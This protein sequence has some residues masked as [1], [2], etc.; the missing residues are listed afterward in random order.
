MQ[1]NQRFC[2]DLA[3]SSSGPPSSKFQDCCWFI[4]I[5]I[6]T[7]VAPGIATATAPAVVYCY[8]CRFRHCWPVFSGTVVQFARPFG[9]RARQVGVQNCIMFPSPKPYSSKFWS[10]HAWMMSLVFRGPARASQPPH[11]LPLPVLLRF[12]FCYCCCCCCCCC[13]QSCRYGD[14]R[15]W[16]HY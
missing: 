10:T 5:A 6:A 8:G 13:C 11:P 14:R 7:A 1:Q 12:C 9:L 16:R 4:S 3:P 15:R 2:A